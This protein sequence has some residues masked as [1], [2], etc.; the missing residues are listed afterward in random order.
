MLHRTARVCSFAVAPV[1]MARVYAADDDSSPKKTHTLRPSDVSDLFRL[2][3]PLEVC[4]PQLIL[5][6]NMNSIIM[7]IQLLKC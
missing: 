2:F 5:A 3:Y 4:D 1:I 6:K 7:I